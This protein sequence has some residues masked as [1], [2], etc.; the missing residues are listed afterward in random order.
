MFLQAI[1]NVQRI[2]ADTVEGC[3]VPTDG[4]EGGNEIDTQIPSRVAGV[5][6]ANIPT[7]QNMVHGAE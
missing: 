5:D 2:A 1:L 3:C 4:C 7:I 6:F